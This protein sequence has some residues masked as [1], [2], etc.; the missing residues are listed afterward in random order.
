MSWDPLSSWWSIRPHH[1]MTPSQFLVEQTPGKLPS[2][3]ILLL[4]FMC[5]S[6]AQPFPSRLLRH[7]DS[8]NKAI[9]SP[10]INLSAPRLVFPVWFHL[11]QEFTDNWY[12]DLLHLSLKI[13]FTQVYS[14]RE[15]MGTK[16]R[17]EM[18]VKLGAIAQILLQ[19]ILVCL[20]AVA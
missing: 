14:T 11:H 2:I 3:G 12:F 5:W 15:G 17:Q 9:L 19:L 4:G 8:S 20:C 6:S 7:A 13:L 18:D 16:I 1:A 10:V